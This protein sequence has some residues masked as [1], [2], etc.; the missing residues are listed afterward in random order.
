MICRNKL[1]MIYKACALI[2]LRMYDIINH[3]KIP[4]IVKNE[5]MK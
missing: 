4:N 3:A 1:R 2:Y 5:V